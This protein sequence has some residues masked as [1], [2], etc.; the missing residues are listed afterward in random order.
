LAL[1]VLEDAPRLEIPLALED[2]RADLD[3]DASTIG[4]GDS[5]RTCSSL[6]SKPPE[7]R[8]SRTSAWM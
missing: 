2:E 4:A 8:T 5:R 6:R 3:V 1:G 7:R